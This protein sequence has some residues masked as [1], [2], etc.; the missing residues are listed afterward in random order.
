M[1]SVDLNMSFF[2]VFLL[3]L[4]AFNRCID[5][6]SLTEINIGYGSLLGDDNDDRVI[7]ENRYKNTAEMIGGDLDGMC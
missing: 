5:L 2:N 1:P 4:P 7:G 6:P 3:H